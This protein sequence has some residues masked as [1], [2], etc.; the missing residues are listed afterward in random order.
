MD[1]QNF[2]NDQNQQNGSVTDSS[3]TGN[4]NYYSSSNDNTSDNTYTSNNTYTSTSSYQDNTSAYGSSYSNAYS[5][6]VVEPEQEGAPGI[7]IAGL[8]M[9]I[10]SIVLFCCCGS[11]IIFAIAGLIMSISGNKQNKSGVGTAG[12]VCSIIGLVLNSLSLIYFIAMFAMGAMS[13]MYY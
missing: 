13:E 4:A 2:Q 1:G 8:V 3:T 10:I 5:Q 9:G 12:L 11:G 6:P 7:S